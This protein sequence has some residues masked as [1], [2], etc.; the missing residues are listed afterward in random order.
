M[1]KFLTELIAS[2]FFLYV[3]LATNGNA[4]AIGAA[5]AIATVFN[6]EVNPAVTTMRVMQGKLTLNN[7]IPIILVQIAGGLIALEM[8]KRVGL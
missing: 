3:I 7:A 4:I 1:N 5:L 8:H 2:T 6:G